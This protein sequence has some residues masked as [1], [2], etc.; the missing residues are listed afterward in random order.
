MLASRICER[1]WRVDVIAESELRSLLVT[2]EQLVERSD[3]L[4]TK[5]RYF[6]SVSKV[7]E[8]GGALSNEPT[9]VLRNV[10]DEAQGRNV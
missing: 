6:E 3:S 8:T 1:K 2:Q 4:K 7:T 10:V 5:T 9:V